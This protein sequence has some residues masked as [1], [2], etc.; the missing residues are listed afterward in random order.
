M[1]DFLKLIRFPNLVIIAFTQY[2]IR[3]GLMY[4]FLEASG[5]ALQMSHP[6]F[7][8]LVLSSVLIAA[9][10]YIINDYFDTKID[11]VNKPHRLIVGRK[12]KRR[13]AMG[14][15]IF[16][17]SAGILLGL[18][19]ALR[20]NAWWLCSIQII[21]A[22]LLWYYSINFKRRILIG[23]VLIAMLTALVPLTSGIY[24]LVLI[25]NNSE[26]IIY[27]LKAIYSEQ[28]LSSIVSYFNTG[29]NSVFFWILGYSLFAFL[30]TFIREVIKDLEDMKGDLEH[31][32]ST[33]PIVFG[34]KKSVLLINIFIFITVFLLA[35][36]QYSQLTVNDLVSFIYFF[37]F[38]Q[39]PLIYISFKLSRA[40]IKKE[41]SL[42]SSLMKI[43]MLF[44]VLYTILIFFQSSPYF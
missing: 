41:F 5:I 26:K 11:L 37:I 34:I 24:E 20:V 23:N 28:S 27:G 44:G 14:L 42:A 40:K 35:I 9:A 2:A 19:I 13:T 32:C 12:I 3:Y 22:I 18:Y 15:H 25:E 17:T 36:V 21:S 8:L 1:E 31:H 30:L 4:P 6:D 39:I 38:L 43:I 7:F 33:F 29:W 10:G 16:I